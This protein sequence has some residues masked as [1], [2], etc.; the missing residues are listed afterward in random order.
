[1]LQKTKIKNDMSRMIKQNIDF[2][3]SIPADE[4]SR[5]V[6]S[7]LHKNI[8][9]VENTEVYTNV[10]VAG[11]PNPRPNGTGEIQGFVCVC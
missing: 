11:G 7:V 4:Q 10:S 2:N 3:F 8:W 9:N 6:R 1:M 5:R